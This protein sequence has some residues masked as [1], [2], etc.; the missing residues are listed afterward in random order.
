MRLA[1]FILR[2][3]GR[4]LAEWEALATTLLPARTKPEFPR[5]A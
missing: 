3:R 5:A 4:L 1:D 2:D